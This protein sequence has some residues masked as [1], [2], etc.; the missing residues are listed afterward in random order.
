M[1]AK[2]RTGV[3]RSYLGNYREWCEQAS[4]KAQNEMVSLHSWVLPQMLFFHILFARN[5][6]WCLYP[7]SLRRQNA[8]LQAAQ[9]PS[10]FKNYPSSTSCNFD[11]GTKQEPLPPDTRGLADQRTPLLGHN[12]WSRNGPWPKKE[13]C[14]YRVFSGDLY[15]CWGSLF[16]EVMRGAYYSK[17]Y[18]IGRAQ[19]ME[20]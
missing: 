5:Q 12:K 16:I 13:L 19:D 9:S 10:H 8:L 6:P 1:R 20:L 4:L 18:L 14:L 11:T 17:N 7:L 2:E 3:H 15:R